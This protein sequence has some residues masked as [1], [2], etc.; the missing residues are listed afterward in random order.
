[1]RPFSLIWASSALNGR[2]AWSHSL[3][4]IGQNEKNR[5]R[6]FFPHLIKMEYA[7]AWIMGLL[8]IFLLQSCGWPY[9]CPKSIDVKPNIVL[10]DVWWGP[11]SCAVNDLQTELIKSTKNA[12]LDCLLLLL[13]LR[14][15]KLGN[16]ARLGF[17]N[18]VASHSANAD[19]VQIEKNE[20]KFTSHGSLFVSRLFL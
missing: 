1:M 7:R 16:L 3:I 18:R 12:A 9:L 20:R 17:R 10:V 19:S 2:W 15:M 13:E 8:W 5:R 6:H 11:N 14:N 4:Y